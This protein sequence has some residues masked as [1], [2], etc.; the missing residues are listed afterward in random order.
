MFDQRGVVGWS[1]PLRLR[2]ALKG[3]VTVYGLLRERGW[4][5]IEKG[6]PR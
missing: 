5:Q 3:V 1:A 6:S 2:H 4:K